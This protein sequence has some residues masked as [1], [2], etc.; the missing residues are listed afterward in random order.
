MRSLSNELLKRRRFSQTLNVC[1]PARRLEPI[2]PFL[3]RRSFILSQRVSIRWWRASRTPT[4][5][6]AHA[7]GARGVP[8]SGS[9]SASARRKL[10]VLDGR[11]RGRESKFPP[12]LASP[13][14]EFRS[15]KIR[16]G[17]D[18]SPCPLIEP[19]LATT[20]PPLP[21]GAPFIRCNS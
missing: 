12:R 20:P 14:S 16:V 11:H 21:R 18:Q 5:E 2:L 10:Q 1:L 15:R 4:H 6:Y 7:R 13:T 3:H 9:T 19:T 17:A 8:E